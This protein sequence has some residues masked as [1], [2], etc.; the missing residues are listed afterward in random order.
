MQELTALPVCFGDLD[1]PNVILCAGIY[2]KLQKK[3]QP[4]LWKESSIRIR[5]WQVA[6]S[7]SNT[8]RSK[9]HTCDQKSQWAEPMLGSY[10]DSSPLPVLHGP[11]P[12]ESSIFWLSALPIDGHGF[13]LHKSFAFSRRFVSLVLVATWE[14]VI[15]L[16]LRS[17]VPCEQLCPTQLEGSPHQAWGENLTL[18]HI[19]KTKLVQGNDASWVKNVEDGQDW[20]F[21][22]MA[23][24]EEGSR[25]HSLM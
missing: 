7:H 9:V 23:F 14:L 25:M 1:Q 13:A 21:L 10:R 3:L 12:G 6:T 4:H 18:S 20:M 2:M 24:R 15:P 19:C 8:P 11:C 22:H 17:P 16:Q 5:D